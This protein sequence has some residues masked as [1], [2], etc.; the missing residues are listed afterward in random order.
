MKQEELR[1]FHR[2]DRL[3][4][5]RL[6]QEESPSLLRFATWL[7]GNSDEAEDLAQETWVTAYQ[8]RKM[9]EDRS[10][11]L[12]WLMTIC[13]SQFLSERRTAD[14]RKQLLAERPSDLPGSSRSDHDVSADPLAWRRLAEALSELPDRQRDV[15]IMRLVHDLSTRTCAYRLKVAE[16]TIKSLLSRGLAALRPLLEDFRP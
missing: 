15:I 2:G 14:R 11:L 10:P 9:Y 6:V 1:R 5:R 7:C 4:F 13:R 8:Q 16:G 12:S 3:L